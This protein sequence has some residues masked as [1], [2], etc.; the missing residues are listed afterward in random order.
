MCKQHALNVLKMDEFADCKEL[1]GYAP[2]DGAEC[3]HPHLV[4]H[5]DLNFKVC[6]SCG[7]AQ[8]IIQYSPEWRYHGAR[9]SKYAK[10]PSRCHFSSASTGSRNIRTTLDVLKFPEAIIA[11]TDRKYQSVVRKYHSV[12]GK[13]TIR[14]DKR[15][16]ILA[17]CLWKA[18]QEA[19]DV[20]ELR[21][22]GQMLEVQRKHLSKGLTAYNLAYPQERTEIITPASLLPRILQRTQLAMALLPLVKK[23]YLQIAGTSCVLN[24]SNPQ[25]VAA[26][27]PW[28]FLCLN[29]DV[30]QKHGLNKR[31][32]AQR[33]GLSEITITKLAKEAA[34][35]LT[36]VPRNLKI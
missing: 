27:I 21:E 25:S 30:K 10:D 22:I 24:R 8:E 36:A 15:K 6:A 4:D 35:S 23:L 13:K 5:H 34:K 9:D 29:P 28:L 16:G 2:E 32:Y 12:V 31:K 20:R 7:E 14:G 17:V 26:A 18:L 3:H 19:E 1:R 11:A 33:A